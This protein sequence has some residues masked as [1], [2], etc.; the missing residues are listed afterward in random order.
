MKILDLI[1]ERDNNTLCPIRVVALIGALEFLAIIGY[2]ALEQHVTTLT[3]LATGLGV[4]IGA[5]SAA[6]TGK[7][8]WS[9]SKGNDDATK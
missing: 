9:E 6:V 7:A 4:L 3:E 1:T 2:N 8:R 5:I